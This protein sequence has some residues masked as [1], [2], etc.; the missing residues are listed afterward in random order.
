MAGQLCVSHASLIVIVVPCVVDY[1]ILHTVLVMSD[2][3]LVKFYHVEWFLC[4]MIDARV[5]EFHCKLL[6]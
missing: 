2:R 6:N 3:I 5:T 4:R 1:C